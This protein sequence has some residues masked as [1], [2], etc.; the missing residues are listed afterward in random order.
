MKNA[1]TG[2]NAA[3]MASER[4]LPKR[5]VHG[6]VGA[7]PDPTAPRFSSDPHCGVCKHHVCNC[8]QRYVNEPEVCPG[9]RET[10]CTKCRPMHESPTC[11]GV[12]GPYGSWP[13]DKT[14]RQC[15]ELSDAVER[16]VAFNKR[17]KE[18]ENA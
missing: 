16:L 4:P 8:E 17:T 2:W 1:R 15:V 5:K 12:F 6:P 7:F 13:T 14:C 11:T 10:P 18:R 9:C 3:K